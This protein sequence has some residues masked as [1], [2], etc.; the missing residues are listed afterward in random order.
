MLC[1]RIAFGYSLGLLRVGIGGVGALRGFVSGFRG[2][3]ASF[4]FWARSFPTLLRVSWFPVTVLCAASLGWQTLNGAADVAA[5]EAHAAWPGYILPPFGTR[6][7]S[8]LWAL[9]QLVALSSAAVAVHRVVQADERRPGE[10]FAF[11]FGRREAAYAGMGLIAYGLVG[12]ILAGQYVAQ[13]TM[14]DLGSIADF[15]L[16]AF[17]GMGPFALGLVI[18]PGELSIFGMPPLN[19]ALWCAVVIATGAVALRL[20]VWPAAVADRGDVGV[21]AALQATRGRLPIVLGYIA[22][23]CVVA[24]I[25]LGVLAIGGLFSLEAGGTNALTQALKS[26]G[27]TGA[28]IETAKEIARYVSDLFGVTLGAVLTSRLYLLLRA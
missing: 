1:R 9:L 25:A 16:T 23:V 3:F 11:S 20:V 7:A 15:T 13:L 21:V 6:E 4:W 17:A 12:A 2:A 22:G 27:G 8:L 10:W 14:P 26:P 5:H 28:S 18:W 24:A 19:Y